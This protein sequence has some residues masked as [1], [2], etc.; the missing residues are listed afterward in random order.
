M[1]NS[2]DEMD[3][4]PYSDTLLVCANWKCDECPYKLDKCPKDV[5]NLEAVGQL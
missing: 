5:V 2:E 4:C 3:V 1:N